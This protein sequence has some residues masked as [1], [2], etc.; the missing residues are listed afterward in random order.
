MAK[1][2]HQIIRPEGIKSEAT[3]G[4]PT[5]TFQD[6]KDA[7]QNSDEIPENYKSDI[8]EFLK[9]LFLE[10]SLDI[11]EVVTNTAPP[12]WLENLWPVVQEILKKLVS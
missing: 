2:E 10:K 8:I 6:V 1:G 12:E 9:E 5:V 3:V 7:I 11:Y 4:Q